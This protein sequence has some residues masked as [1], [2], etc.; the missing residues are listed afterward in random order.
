M[1]NYWMKETSSRIGVSS[2]L[3]VSSTA[4]ATTAAF[5]S[6]T[7]QVRVAAFGTDVFINIGD[8]T[9][10]VTTS[11]LRLAANTFDYFS[12]TPGQKL[13]ALGAAGAATVSVVEMS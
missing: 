12:T 10:A 4:T 3:S 13:S 1:P 9:P 5:S 2:A 6:Q 8:G 11:S 7:Y